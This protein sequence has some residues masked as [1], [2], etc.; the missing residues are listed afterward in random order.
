MESHDLE[1]SERLLKW[2]REILAMI[3]REMSFGKL[4]MRRFDDGSEIEEEGVERE[5]SMFAR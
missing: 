3:C 4:G 1:T 2:V 5:L